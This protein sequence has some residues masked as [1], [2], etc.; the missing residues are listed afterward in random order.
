M[1]KVSVLIF[2]GMLGGLLGGCGDKTEA[3]SLS[4][5]NNFSESQ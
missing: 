5:Y 4:V 1:K 3:K 2:I